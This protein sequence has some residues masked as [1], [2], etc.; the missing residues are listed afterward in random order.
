MTV[1]QVLSQ[2]HVILSLLGVECYLKQFSCLR[3][4]DRKHAIKVITPRSALY[5]LHIIHQAPFKQ[6][7][8]SKMGLNGLLNFSYV[9]HLCIEH[10]Q[11]MNLIVGLEQSEALVVC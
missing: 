11:V 5:G 6:Y 10:V 3:E 1:Y 7:F 8:Y 4:A 9:F 2:N